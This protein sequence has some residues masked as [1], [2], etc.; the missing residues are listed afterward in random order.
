MQQSCTRVQITLPVSFQVAYIHQHAAERKN[1][2]D[3]DNAKGKPREVLV[4]LRVPLVDIM[5]Q[6]EEDPTLLSE[7]DALSDPLATWMAR[8]YGGDSSLAQLIVQVRQS[9]ETDEEEPSEDEADVLGLFV[10]L[11][12]LDEAAAVR[13][14]GSFVFGSAV[15]SGALPFS[16]ADFSAGDRGFPRTRISRHHGLRCVPHVSFVATSFARAGRLHP[17]A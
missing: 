1:T 8:K 10:L 2:A 5:R 7:P 4:P 17:E 3:G 12:G 14:N 16:L 9:Q 11:D 13:T 6:M 15:G